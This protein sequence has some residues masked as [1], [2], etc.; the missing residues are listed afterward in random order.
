MDRNRDHRWLRAS[1]RTASVLNCRA[2]IFVRPRVI[3]FCVH[4]IIKGVEQFQKC[5]VATRV[6]YSE[7]FLLRFLIDDHRSAHTYKSM[8]STDCLGGVI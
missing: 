5:L 1:G 6:S 3:L 4:L 8:G 7:N 2:R